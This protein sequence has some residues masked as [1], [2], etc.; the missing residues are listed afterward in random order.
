MTEKMKVAR[1][2][3][4]RLQKTFAKGSWDPEQGRDTTSSAL[5][6]NRR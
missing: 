5:E 4:D 2:V 6:I 1:S 3:G